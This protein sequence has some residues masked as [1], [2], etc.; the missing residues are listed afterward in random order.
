M[1]S[2][3]EKSMKMR[4][5]IGLVAAAMGSAAM[6]QPVSPMTLT[7]GVQIS[8]DVREDDSNAA[9]LGGFWVFTLG[10]AMDVDIDINRLLADPD[11]AATLYEGDVTGADMTAF[12]PDGLINGILVGS[13]VFGPL[14]AIAFEDDTEDDAFGGPFGDPR[15]TMNL[16]AGTYTLMVAA[17]NTDVIGVDAYEVVT[18][19]VPAL[20]SLALLG[21]G[22]L[23]GL[24][25]RR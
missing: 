15:F 22:G 6:A 25:R 20:A 19:L 3:E 10:A 16:P 12:S 24:R 4:H 18:N 11:L 23:V 21:L 9:S 13:G 2:R 8:Q 7:G 17:L 5:G 1:Y 14:T